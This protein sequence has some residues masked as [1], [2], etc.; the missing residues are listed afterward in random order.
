VWLYG[1]VI[2]LSSSANFIGVNDASNW[3]HF[4]LGVVF[5]LV[6]YALSRRDTPRDTNRA[7]AA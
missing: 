5:L 2:D 4:V 1:L 6:G 7:A 3:L